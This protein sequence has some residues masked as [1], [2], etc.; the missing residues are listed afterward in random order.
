MYIY[1]Y[2]YIEHIHTHHIYICTYTYK[3]TYTT[4]THYT[5]HLLHPMDF[6]GLRCGR[7]GAGRLLRA[8]HGHRGLP[9]HHRTHDPRRAQGLGLPWFLGAWENH[10]KTMGKPWENGG[11]HSGKRLHSY[12]KSPFLMEKSSVHGPFSIEFTSGYHHLM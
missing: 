5:H 11:L 2:T 8:A 1:I 6:R 9:G 10:R 3:H 12:G 4:S 7:C